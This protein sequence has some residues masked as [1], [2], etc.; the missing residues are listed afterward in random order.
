MGYE[1]ENLNVFDLIDCSMTF[2]DFSILSLSTIFLLDFG[3]VPRSVVFFFPFY[4]FLNGL[5]ID[6]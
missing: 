1:G 4:S 2:Y 3:N 5:Y 6:Y